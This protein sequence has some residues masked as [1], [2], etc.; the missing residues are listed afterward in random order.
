[1]EEL[2]ARVGGVL[3]KEGKE[4]E[5]YAAVLAEMK[6]ALA[7]RYR[8]CC[9]LVRA[10]EGLECRTFPTRRTAERSDY[11]SSLACRSPPRGR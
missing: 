8:Q 4:A 7:L 6:L 3:K 11:P 5:E 2:T 9:E 1:M 10:G